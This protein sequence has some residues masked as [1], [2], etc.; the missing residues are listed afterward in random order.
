MVILTGEALPEAS[1]RRDETADP[2]GASAAEPLVHG[3]GEPA[4][5][6]GTAEVRGT[7]DKPNEP[8]VT[9]GVRVTDPELNLVE[10]LG[11]IDD[12]LVHALDGSAECLEDTC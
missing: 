1:Q 11:A 12:G 6:E 10:G 3:L 8:R 7:V 4:A 9:H 2:D 5:D